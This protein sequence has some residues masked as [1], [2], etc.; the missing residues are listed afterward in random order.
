MNGLEGWKHVWLSW[1]AVT[2]SGK[3]WLELRQGVE[4]L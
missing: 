1:K 3:N 4:I 2:L